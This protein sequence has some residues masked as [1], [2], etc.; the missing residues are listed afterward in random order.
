M[1]ARLNHEYPVVKLY[2]FKILN[3][4][5]SLSTRWLYSTKSSWFFSKLSFKWLQV[6]EALDSVLEMLT[7]LFNLVKLRQSNDVRVMLRF[8][9][10]I[11][12]FL[13]IE[14][15]ELF[16]SNLSPPTP[17][18]TFPPLSLLFDAYLC[19]SCDT[20]NPTLLPLLIPPM[21]Y[22]G[23]ALPLLLLSSDK[24]LDPSLLELPFRNLLLLLTRMFLLRMSESLETLLTLGSTLV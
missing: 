7:L 20:F 16:C 9:F 14:I 22:A 6:I 18:P 4:L 12:K 2:F 10:G 3:Y 17:Y 15:V 1:F 19:F 8:Y 21:P 11:L 5:N 13:F 23:A 24:S